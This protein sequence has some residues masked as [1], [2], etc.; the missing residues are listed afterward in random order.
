MAQPSVSNASPRT[1]GSFVDQVK[2]RVALLAFFVGSMWAVF[3]LSVSMPF[4]HLN[5]HGV[6]PRTLGGLQGIVFAPWLHAGLWHIAANTGGLVLLGWLAMWPR[7]ANFWQATAGAILG[8]GL[9]AWLLGA[10]DSVHIGA[11]GVVF[12]YAGYLVA[13]G[14]YTRG[15]LSILIALFVVS[16]YGLSMLLGALPIYPGMSWQSHLGGAMGGIIAARL[17]RQSLRP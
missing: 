10:P 7:I 15:I 2:A 1:A 17:S 11:S 14:F 4:L 6:V 9:C 3:L 16:S 5:R 8:A 13:R 12:G